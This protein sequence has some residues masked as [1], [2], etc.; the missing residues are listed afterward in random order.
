[1]LQRFAHTEGSVVRQP[2]GAYIHE[3]SLRDHLGNT[4]VTFTDADNNGFVDASDIKQINHYY[5]FGLNMEGNWQG[6]AQGDNKYQYNDKEWNDDFG[7]G[8][9]DYGARWYDPA[10]GRWNSVDPLAEMYSR[11]SPYNYCVDNPM[12][13]T[14]PTGMSA[15]PG[16]ETNE[17]EDYNNQVGRGAAIRQWVNSAMKSDK[18]SHWDD[19]Y[20]G[21]AQNDQNDFS[22]G[23]YISQAD[24]LN[25]HNSSIGAELAAEDNHMDEDDNGNIKPK[26]K[27]QAADLMAKSFIDEIKTVNKGVVSGIILIWLDPALSVG[28][29]I[30]PDGNLPAP[31]QGLTDENKK[32]VSITQ[33]MLDD[34]NR[35]IKVFNKNNVKF[36]DGTNG[37]VKLG[38]WVAPRKATYQSHSQGKRVGQS[39]K[40]ERYNVIIWKKMLPPPPPPKNPNRV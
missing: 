8:L 38:V 3:Y 23:D 20:G 4:R 7:L 5:P 13:H 1:V 15:M 36:G 21:D 22:R 27:E 2:S 35:I 37:T 16:N 26:S 40:R 14:D 31:L 12:N 17:S 19:A 28:K 10:L 18:N 39:S 25:R 32:G 33:G 30:V 24:K 34:Y 6:G 29:K 11:W 9:N